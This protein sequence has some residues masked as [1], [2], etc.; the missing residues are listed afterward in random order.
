MEWGPDHARPGPVPLSLAGTTLHRMALVEDGPTRQIQKCAAL[1][2]CAGRDALDVDFDLFT[3]NGRQ[4][5]LGEGVFAQEVNP[6]GE[7]IP[8]DL[9]PMSCTFR[10]VFSSLVP[11]LVVIVCV[12]P[13]STFANSFIDAPLSELEIQIVSKDVLN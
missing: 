3:Q 5:R 2:A 6:G 11:F 9:M 8:V 7:Q 13:C 1:V 12:L 4:F 10:R